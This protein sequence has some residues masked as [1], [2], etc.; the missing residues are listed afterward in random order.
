MLDV[1]ARVICAH[2]LARSADPKSARD[3]QIGIG[4]GSLLPSGLIESGMLLLMHEIRR[5]VAALPPT[6]GV[7]SEGCLFLWRPCVLSS[8]ARVMCVYDVHFAEFGER[9]PLLD[10]SGLLPIPGPGG[11]A[12]ASG[13]DQ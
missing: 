13:P 1:L 9:R 8:G 5:S 4:A 3:R 10:E 6:R 2:V 12:E 7:R 11:A